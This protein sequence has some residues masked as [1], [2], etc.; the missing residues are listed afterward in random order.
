MSHIGLGNQHGL[1]D[2]FIIMGGVPCVIILVGRND[3]PCWN[4]F[5]D[6]SSKSLIKPFVLCQYVCVVP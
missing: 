5:F 1:V 3:N 6:F 2:P 4:G